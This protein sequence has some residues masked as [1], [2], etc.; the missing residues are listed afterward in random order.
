MCRYGSDN[1]FAAFV[2]GERRIAV[3]ASHVTKQLQFIANLERGGN[4]STSAIAL[5]D[6]LEHCQM[7]R[8]AECDQIAREID[9][10][11]GE[12]GPEDAV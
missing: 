1:T 9:S 8:M 2:A 12:K 7:T 10:L 4:N 11:L 6:R 5:P 3:G